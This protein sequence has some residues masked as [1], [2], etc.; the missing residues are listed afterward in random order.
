MLA[1]ERSQ[2]ILKELED[3]GRVR[4]NDLSKTLNVSRMTI[5]RDISLLAE[6]GLLEKVF[7]GAVAV[8]Q[9][10]AGNQ[11]C[12]MCGMGNKERTA[13]VVNCADGSQLQAC[14]PHC[15]IMVLAARE[16]AISAMAADFLHG[17]MINVRSA[18]FLVDPEL[19]VCCTP[20]VL[21]FQRHDEV[22]KFQR[23]FGGEVMDLQQTQNYLRESMMLGHD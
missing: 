8:V 2:F 18:F 22:K 23:G 3:T 21:C 10:P 4:V 16:Q 15:G 17:R 20:T 9:E 5:H 11:G 19:S 12:V 7:G 14:C 1:S 13:F 6:K